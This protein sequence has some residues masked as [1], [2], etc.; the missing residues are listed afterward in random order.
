MFARLLEIVTYSQ[1]LAGGMGVVVGYR[2]LTRPVM[3]GMVLAQ[4]ENRVMW[5]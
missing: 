4:G 1:L 2:R 5:D 3:C